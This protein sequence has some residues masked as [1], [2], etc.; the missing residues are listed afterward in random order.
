MVNI[1]ITALLIVINLYFCLHKLNKAKWLSWITIG[2][3]ILSIIGQI[4]LFILIKLKQ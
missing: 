4:T 3:L 2:I 1:I